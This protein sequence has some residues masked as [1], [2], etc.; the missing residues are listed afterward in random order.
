MTLVYL[1][2]GKGAGGCLVDSIF[3]DLSGSFDLL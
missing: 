3:S 1:G 2:T